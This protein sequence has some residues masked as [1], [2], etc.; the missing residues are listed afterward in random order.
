M[1]SNEPSNGLIDRMH[2]H[3]GCICVTFFHY[4][5][6][7]ESSNGLQKKMPNHIDCICLTFSKICVLKLGPQIACIRKCIVTLVAFA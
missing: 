2:S 4:V 6:L 7:N 5:F 1:F 3:I